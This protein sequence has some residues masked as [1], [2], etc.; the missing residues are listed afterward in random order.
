MVEAKWCHA[1]YV[2]TYDEY[3]VNGIWTSTFSPSIISFAGLGKFATENVFSWISSDPKII[4]AASIIGRLLDE[5]A[6]HEVI[7]RFFY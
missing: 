7:I 2:P 5:V 1:G 3:K 4:E 6:S